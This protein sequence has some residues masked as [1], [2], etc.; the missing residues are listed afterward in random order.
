MGPLLCLAPSSGVCVGSA[1]CFSCS[2]LL[3]RLDAGHADCNRPICALFVPTLRMLL[4]CKTA[5]AYQEVV[6]ESGRL[7]ASSE[8]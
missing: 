1:V 6:Y 4:G 3:S 7:H 8:V 2:V 5:Y